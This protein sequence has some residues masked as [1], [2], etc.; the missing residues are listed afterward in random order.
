MDLSWRYESIDE[1]KHS[2]PVTNEKPIATDRMNKNIQIFEGNRSE[3]LNVEF[4]SVNDFSMFCQ[5]L[6]N[7]GILLFENDIKEVGESYS[8]YLSKKI[9]KPLFKRLFSSYDDWIIIY[10]LE[11]E[12]GRL[13]Y[14]FTWNEGDGSNIYQLSRDN[15]PSEQ[16]Q[17]KGREIRKEIERVLSE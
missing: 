6:E 2:Q 5:T 16:I 10:K 15:Y 13:F 7:R 8:T 12:N 14:D 4:S 11:Y 9:R 1:L 3:F 17:E